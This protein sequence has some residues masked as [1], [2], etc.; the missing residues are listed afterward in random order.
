[1]K[2]LVIIS[3]KGGTGKTSITAAF[4]GLAKHAVLADCD[5]DAADLHL[6]MAPK[7]VQQESFIGGKVAEIDP[8]RC[9]QCGQ[10]LQVC[11]FDAITVDFRIQPIACEGCGV[12]VWNCP[13]KAIDFNPRK[14]GDWF[15]SKTR[16]GTMVHAKLGIA[17]ENSG[18]LV[19]KV[20]KQARE[21]AEKQKAEFL[22]VDGPPG[23]GCPVIAAIGGA[24]HALIVTEP[25]RS[26]IHDMKRTIELC[27][28]FKIPM[29]VCI[30][31]ADINKELTGSIE[32]FCQDNGIVVAGKIP[33]DS[34]LTKAQIAGKTI[35]EFDNGPLQDLFVQLWQSLSARIQVKEPINQEA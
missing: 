26:A 35:T 24:D 7:V 9:S 22:L 28:H 33:Y 5:V 1:M 4:A 34:A 12:C 15:I 21:V 2:E 16:F 8:R 23:I 17:E 32:I 18:K 30:N 6:V 14:S 13:E 11:R 10:C 19:T 3:G 31:R 25:S 20:R 27:N 29:T